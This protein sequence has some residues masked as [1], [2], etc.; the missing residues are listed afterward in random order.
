VIWGRSL[1]GLARLTS[2]VLLL[3]AL[4]LAGCGGSSRPSPAQ[5]VTYQ[6]E[7]FD[8]VD[9]QRVSSG[10]VFAGQNLLEGLVTPDAAGTGVVPAT[11][12]RWTVS[13]NDT[14]Y[15][16][17]IRSDAKWSDGTPVTARDFE[18]TYRR[19]LTPSTSTQE[20][21][22]NGASGYHPD[23]GI[24]HA[25]D[26]QSGTVTK[27]SEVGVK[28][29][30]ASHLRIVLAA[31]NAAF[32][33]GMAQPAMVALS[34][35]N[36]TRFPYSWQEAAH[37]VGNGP[38]V[39]K[40]WTPNSS[41]VLVPNEHYWDR[42]TVHL[43]RVNVLLTA[44]TDAQVKARYQRH[45]LDI[46]P[47]ID[48]SGFAKD[49]ALSRALTHI[50]Q[51][52]VLFLTLIPS[53]NPALRDVRVRRAIAL[54]IGRAQAAKGSSV[55]EPATA[56]M[57][58]NLSGFDASVGFRQD[59]A[60]ARRLMA[61]AGY[62]GGK[63]FPTFII[64][65]SSDDPYVQYVRA[66]VRTLRR[67]LGI[68]AVADVEDVGV[69]NA[70]RHE[71]LPAHRV[72]Y[73]TTSYTGIRAWRMW[74]SSNF[75]PSQAELLSLTP[76]DYTHYQVLQAGGTARSLA[77]ADRFLQAH[78]S[79]QSRRFAAM[80]ARADATADP[81]RATALDKQAAAIRQQTFEFIPFM[82]AEKPYAIRPG[83]NGVHLW[84]GYFTISFKGVSVN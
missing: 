39:I 62:P 61:E 64:M 26:Y 44:T 22:L 42:Q 71:V 45:Q 31:P 5:V 63:G 60:Q 68:N 4:P 10:Q 77:A 76:A 70:K 74:V 80:A 29:L 16:F 47:L 34:E 73:F 46:A 57:P 41:M 49:A 6:Y 21:A 78:A 51:Y 82:Y 14:V 58:S 36:L 48:P 9:P 15:T 75:P 65:D 55:V 18:W 69:E 56:L 30:D 23:L 67:N 2:V 24:K 50:P 8:Q 12:D 35:R 19:L 52:A 38:F 54:G 83:I 79:P 7:P 1:T 40:S 53:R 20:T 3:T 81:E 33:Q 66:V 13:R 84:T 32:L 25:T 27:W 72:G 43:K 37:W 17:H 28:A 11:A 59:I